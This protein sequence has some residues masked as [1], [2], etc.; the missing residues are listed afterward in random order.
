MTDT[1]EEI[2][3]SVQD[4]VETNLMVTLDDFKEGIT[5]SYMVGKNKVV[6]VDSYNQIKNDYRH[7]LTLVMT[8]MAV[9]YYDAPHYQGKEEATVKNIFYK[10]DVDLES[11]IV[12]EGL[13][14]TTDLLDRLLA[15]MVLELPFTYANSLFK[16]EKPYE[17][18]LELVLP[19]YEPFILFL[20]AE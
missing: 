17:E 9:D 6:D 3:E 19:A 15:E 16:N 7:V 1:L 10:Y 14:Y 13:S 20:N 8:K 2:L 4:Y 5:P 18:F 12:R 11:A